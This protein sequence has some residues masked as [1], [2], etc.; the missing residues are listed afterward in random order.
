MS[1][2]P[3]GRTDAKAPGRALVAIP[4]PVDAGSA[5]RELGEVGLAATLAFTSD[6]VLRLVEAEPFDLIA[7]DASLVPVP[8]GAV[9][10]SEAV[11]LI[12]GDAPAPLLAQLGT[13]AGANLGT[14]ATAG[15]VAERAAVLL[16]SSPEH[17]KG[18]DLRAWGPLELD[19]GRRQAY[20]HSHPLDLTPTQFR[21][22]LALVD[23]EGRLVTKQELQEYAWGV[24]T[25]TD[26]ERL[27]A[28]VRR[29][30]T[31]IEADPSQPSFLLTVRGEGFRLERRLREVSRRQGRREHRE[32]RRFAHR[33]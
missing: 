6:Q 31:K 9:A 25:A 8:P 19:V 17:E 22:L 18:P 3:F 28:H 14:D 33:R 12:L 2:Q 10:R 32:R 21:L 4:S 24:S 1:T 5:A 20:W 23:A 7:I 27:S 29:I 13:R 26:D 16:R 15:E 30:R 11:V